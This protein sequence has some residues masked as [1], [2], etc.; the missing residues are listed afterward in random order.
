[1][2]SSARER[3]S[4][5]MVRRSARI[6]RR[7]AR[8][9]SRTEDVPGEAIEGFPAVLSTGPAV[10]LS[11]MN[12]TFLRSRENVRDPPGMKRET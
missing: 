2:A 7:R 9:R 11:F 1:M 6:S 10:C 8:L 5:G 3:F 12:T 4:G